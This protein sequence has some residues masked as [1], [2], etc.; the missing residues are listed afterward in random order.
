[1]GTGGGIGTGVIFGCLRWNEG[2]CSR[3]RRESGERGAE[4][5][6]ATLGRCTPE[7]EMVDAWNETDR[8]DPKAQGRQ[9][10][11]FLHSRR[12]RIFQR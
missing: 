12:S 4:T 8:L 3:V 7:K 1:M 5:G 10:I 6:G 2:G 9:N 11:P